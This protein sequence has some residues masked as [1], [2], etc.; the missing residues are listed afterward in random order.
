MSAKKLIIEIP[1]TE[2]LEDFFSQLQ[3]AVATG[4]VSFQIKESVWARLEDP[5]Q[6]KV[7]TQDLI[8][9][10]ISVDNPQAGTTPRAQED[11][12]EEEVTIGESSP[13][14]Q[15]GEDEDKIPLS[16]SSIQEFKEF[17]KMLTGKRPRAALATRG[18]EQGKEPK[19]TPATQAVTQSGATAT[20]SGATP[21]TGNLIGA[22]ANPKVEGRPQKIA[23]RPFGRGPI[24]QWK[25]TPAP[26]HLMEA[27]TL[28]S[29]KTRVSSADRRGHALSVHL[30]SYFGNEYEEPRLTAIQKM[31]YRME[32]IYRIMNFLGHDTPAKRTHK[33]CEGLLYPVFDSTT[34][35]PL[36]QVTVKAF[37]LDEGVAVPRRWFIAEMGTLGLACWQGGMSLLAVLTVEEREKLLPDLMSLGQKVIDQQRPRRM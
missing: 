22:T 8:D 31:F 27:C 14:K 9:L 1:L 28:M 5:V 36:D 13:E 18:P 37:C 33:V 4:E 21:K 30:P 19:E 17:L 16:Q 29:C 15:E 3:V 25:P 23:A 6:V 7:E 24:W 20:G 10:Q 2:G 26:E 12:Y 11:F 34:M 35:A 32:F